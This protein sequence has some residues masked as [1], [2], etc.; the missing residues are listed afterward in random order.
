MRLQSSL[1]FPLAAALVAVT[2]TA[3]NY[4][5]HPIDNATG[6]TSQNIPFAGG[7]VNWDEARSQF[8]VT[9]PY[10]PPVGALITQSELVPNT[11]GTFDYDRF[12]IWMDHTQNTTLSMNFASNLSA[13]PTLVFSRNPGQISWVGG[14]WFAL[15]LD[16]PFVHDG[17][18]NLVIEVRKKVNRNNPPA[19]SVSHRI[20]IWPRRTDLQPPI[21]TY[22][23]YGSGAID[24]ATATTTYTTQILMRLQFG[25]ASTMVIDS[26]RD[27]SS[28]TSRSY[29]HL[30]A[31]MTTTVQGP[32]GAQAFHLVGVPLAQSGIP[33]PSIQ[34]ALWI[35]PP[36]I[37]AYGQG[38]L[39][40]SGRHS[41]RLPIPN[42]PGLVG[43]HV[44][45][46]GL[47]IGSTASFTNC[48]D[49]PI[50]Q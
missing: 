37:V 47:T 29:F 23:P 6:S 30:G 4:T 13:N 33:V 45:T 41:A 36:L 50:A 35:F 3:Q 15:T 40:A 38:T 42:D 21:W 17:S 7:H 48:A 5:A 44:F 19:T 1:S 16:T 31:T 8:L 49:A 25:A 32:P 34:G 20:L 26:S 24:G 11:S 27:T 28:S 10:L 9:A 39:D 14:T 22:G 2:A 18:S 46:Q 43:L 12:E